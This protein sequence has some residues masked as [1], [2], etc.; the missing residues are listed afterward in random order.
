MRKPFVAGNWKMNNNSKEASELVTELLPKLS[1]IKNVELVLCPPFTSLWAV[2]ELIAGTGIG[3]GAQNLYWEVS[4][5]YT[6]EISSAM[7]SEVC[8]YVIL[9]H[10]ERRQ[11]FWETDETVNLKVKSAIAHGLIPIVCVGESLDENQAGLTGDI[12]NRQ[13]RNGLADLNAEDGAKVVIAYEPI[14]A[15]GTGLAATPESAN[16]IHK[17]VVRTVLSDMFDEL[18]AQKIRILYGGSVNSENAASFFS[19]SDIDGA[20]VGGASLKAKSFVLIAEAA[21]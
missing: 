1:K 17:G 4:G 10:S 3:L 7:L 13:L 18:T 19:Q 2:K 16:D 12:V 6:G 21:N 8:N 9:G 5:A 20:L 15:I 11:Y 14:W